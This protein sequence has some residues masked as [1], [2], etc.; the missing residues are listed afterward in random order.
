MKKKTKTEVP[1]QP[2]RDEKDVA[3]VGAM[4][5]S[6]LVPYVGG[7]TAEWWG[8]LIARPVDRRRTAWFNTL[9]EA[10]LELQRTGLD[11]EQLKDD[12]AF[13]S[14][15][16]TATLAAAKTQQ[17]KREALKNC[18]LN[19]ALG[20]EPDD[21]IRQIF[22]DLVDRFTPIHLKL[23]A[24]FSN[25]R[26]HHAVASRFQHGGMGGLLYVIQTAYPELVRQDEIVKVVWGDLDATGL[27][28]KVML[29]MTMTGSG[30]LEKRTTELGDRFVSFVCTSPI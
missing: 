6:K 3:Y 5:L 17:E 29:G 14:V 23:L 2:T 22:V 27:V 13:A 10:I 1:E 20:V 18:V 26:A 15:V 28:G 8:S 19:A 12:E 21:S 7:A 9:R 4:I 30:L 24:L 25:P 16:M 11:L